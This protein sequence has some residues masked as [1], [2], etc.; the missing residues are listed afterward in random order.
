MLT[1]YSNQSSFKKKLTVLI[2]WL[3]AVGLGFLLYQI[4]EDEGN[5]FL[6]KIVPIL[7]IIFMIAGILLRCKIARAFTL[8]TFY[9]LAFF[10]LMA[11]LL[12]SESFILFSMDESGMFSTVEILLTNLFWTLL[13][14]IPIYFFSNSKSMD[15]FFIESNPKEHLF[16]GGIALLALYFYV[17]YAELPFFI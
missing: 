14:S 8:I 2:I 5:S 13:F 10:P 16:F 12:T 9:I 11:N 17:T 3:V 1:L 6:V 7:L 15:I 4:I